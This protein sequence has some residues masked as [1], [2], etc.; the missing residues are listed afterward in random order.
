MSY[1]FQVLAILMC[2]L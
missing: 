1:S 2:Q